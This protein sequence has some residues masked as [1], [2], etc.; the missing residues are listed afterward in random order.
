MT[1]LLSTSGLQASYK[2]GSGIIPVLRG[3]DVS[4]EKG[5][6]AAIIG[7][8]G[9]G[10]TTLFYILAGLLRADAGMYTFAGKNMAR[11]N[12]RTQVNLRSHFIGFVP[13]KPAFL[14]KGTLFRNTELPLLTSRLTPA[15]RR[16]RVFAALSSV[17]L[18]SCASICCAELSLDQLQRAAIAQAL[19]IEPDLILADEPLESLDPKNRD[20]ILELFAQQSKL[21]RAVLIATKDPSIS[22]HV[23][24]VYKLEDGA[25]TNLSAPPPPEPEPEPSLTPLSTSSEHETDGENSDSEGVDENSGYAVRGENPTAEVR[26]ENPGFEVSGEN[27]DVEQSSDIPELL[28]I[29]ESTQEAQLRTVSPV[30]WDINDEDSAIPPDFSIEK[31]LQQSNL[32]VGWWRK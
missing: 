26:G 4:L 31:A 2:D 1:T 19:V 5:E 24:T 17:S 32:F 15:K 28:D 9:S 14:L 11:A 13:Q 16:A 30:D 27:L 10:K 21:G 22:E 7:S 3:I 18:A 20:L 6:L 8:P 12:E 29:M 23:S 25:L